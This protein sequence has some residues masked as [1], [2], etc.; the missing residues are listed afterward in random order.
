MG[1][2]SAPGFRQGG[3]ED[4]PLL[5]LLHGLGATGAVWDGLIELLPA[6]WPGGWLAPDLR[7]HG[8][9]PPLSRYSFGGLAARI[10]A[11]LPTDRP[12]AVLGHSLG[13]VLALT[14]ASGWFGVRVTAAAGL[15]IKVR[16]SEEELA[17]AAALA[18]K[19][20]REFATRAE[21]ADRHLKV[22]GLLG[23]V[24][25]DSPA[26]S[27]GLIESDG[28]WRLALDQRA[29]G[30]GAPDLPGLLAA[31][32]CPTVL[33]A[34]EHDPMSPAEHLRAL[35]IEPLVLPGRGHNAHVEAPESLLP[36]LERLRI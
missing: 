24:G 22:S 3:P 25:E 36:V 21:A 29:F 19:P 34:G 13:G 9:A 15:G 28:G 35:V 20:A 12:V 23:L 1:D 6:H 33:A 18:G 31:A 8:A 5:V 4:G 10:A 14:L 27:T 2:T 26:V 17:K 11:H 7:G 32:K 30:V 16:W